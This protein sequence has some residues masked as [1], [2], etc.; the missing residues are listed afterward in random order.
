MSTVCY[1][2]SRF[3]CEYAE[4]S[5]LENKK[6]IREDKTTKGGDKAED[7]DEGATNQGEK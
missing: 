1:L 2:Y 3:K 6:G 5:K 7:K 4:G